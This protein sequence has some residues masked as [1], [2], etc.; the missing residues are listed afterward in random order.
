MQ[1]RTCTT[2]QLQKYFRSFDIICATSVLCFCFHHVP[3][4]FPT[5]S[6]DDFCIQK[7]IVNIFAVAFKC[8]LDKRWFHHEAIDSISIVLEKVTTAFSNSDLFN[9]QHNRHTIQW[10]CGVHSA[11]RMPTIQSHWLVD[12]FV[13]KIISRRLIS[14]RLS[15]GVSSQ[16]TEDEATD[17]MH[18]FWLSL[19]L[20]VLNSWHE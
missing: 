2:K 7:T 8:W 5:H 18:T 19:N 1:Y 17:V 15:S 11:H 4:A 16:N 10:A 3:P 12:L 13:K 20:H 9:C 14:Y 6:V